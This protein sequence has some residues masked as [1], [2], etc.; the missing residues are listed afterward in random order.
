MVSGIPGLS[1][2]DTNNVP[3]TPLVSLMAKLFAISMHPIATE[4]LIRITTHLS[5]KNSVNRFSKETI[6]P[7]GIA[8]TRPSRPITSFHAEREVRMIFLTLPPAVLDATN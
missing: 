7:V 6:T 5:G 8:E 4:D 2:E 1:P 3:A